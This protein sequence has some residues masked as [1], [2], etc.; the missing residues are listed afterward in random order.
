MNVPFCSEGLNFVPVRAFFPSFRPLSPH[1]SPTASRYARCTE[2]NRQIKT[3]SHA[4]RMPSLFSVDHPRTAA[5]RRPFL[6][7]D[8]VS[9]PA[10]HLQKI[11]KKC[12]NTFMCSRI[13]LMHHHA[14]PSIPPFKPPRSRFKPIYP[15]YE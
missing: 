15:F 14:V 1:A 6:G 10:P 2:Q 9:R 5:V 8:G 4:P 13:F 3:G 11:R 7:T 12:E